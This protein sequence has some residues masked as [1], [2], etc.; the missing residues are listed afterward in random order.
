MEKWAR[1][2]AAGHA[3]MP[4]TSFQPTRF[5]MAWTDASQS[6][7]RRRRRKGKTLRAAAPR[8]FD[9][10]ASLGEALRA[11]PP[12]SLREALRAGTG[13]LGEEEAQDAGGM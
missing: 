7:N 4:P 3:V 11:G 12:A 2:V 13:R 1:S 8:D 9:P 6:K 5:A 10:P